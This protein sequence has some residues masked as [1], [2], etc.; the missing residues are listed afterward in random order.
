MMYVAVVIV[1]IEAAAMARVIIRLP[2]ASD[3]RRHDG[4][5]GRRQARFMAA[6]RLI[7]LVIGFLALQREIM[8]EEELHQNHVRL[9]QHVASENA[10]IGP[11]FINRHP[12]GGDGSDIHFGKI[13]ISVMLLVELR[14]RIEIDRA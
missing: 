13:I 1:Q 14:G 2:E 8:A 6:T 12:V 3:F 7:K 4:V 5:N 10:V 11:V 9:F